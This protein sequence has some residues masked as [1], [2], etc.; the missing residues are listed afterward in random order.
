[1]AP[2]LKT[3][4]EVSDL[5]AKLAAVIKHGTLP[6]IG[7]DGKPIPPGKGGPVPKDPTQ[8]RNHNNFRAKNEKGDIPERMSECVTVRARMKAQECLRP[9]LLSLSSSVLFF[10]FR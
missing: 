2:K 4:G 7:K 9:R 10:L 1:M 6:T 8:V 5:K 3:K